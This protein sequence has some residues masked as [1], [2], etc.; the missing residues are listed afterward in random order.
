[1]IYRDDYAFKTKLLNFQ[2]KCRTTNTIY[3]VEQI[4]NAS[5]RRVPVDILDLLLDN[6]KKLLHA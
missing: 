4:G 1:M 6:E 2:L 5:W 3:F